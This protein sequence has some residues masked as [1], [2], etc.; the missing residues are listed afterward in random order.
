MKLPMIKILRVTTIL[1]SILLIGSCNV[2]RTITNGNTVIRTDDRINETVGNYFGELARD[3]AENYLCLAPD[4]YNIIIIDTK[5]SKNKVPKYDVAVVLPWIFRREPHIEKQDLYFDQ[6]VTY[7]AR[8]FGPNSPIPHEVGHLLFGKYI[9]KNGG[10]TNETSQYGSAAPD[11][12]DEAVAIL[13]EA[14][15]DKEA[16]KVQFYESIRNGST[17]ELQSFVNSEHPIWLKKKNKTQ[18]VEPAK[19]VS[20]SGGDSPQYSEEILFYL[21][22]LAFA[23]FLIEKSG[24]NCI[25]AE[26]GTAFSNGQSFESW[27]STQTQIKNINSVGTLEREF[28]DWVTA[29]MNDYP[30]AKDWFKENLSL[31][32]FK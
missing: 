10:W 24:N 14:D 31:D 30:G 32:I 12:L 2:E 3:R 4:S 16:R 1:S 20:G 25:L 27:L 28:F 13:F 11:W 8:S 22:S 6:K 5:K 9:I 23:E 18:N 21:R 29:Q 26:I 15:K 7:Y 19:T 17:F